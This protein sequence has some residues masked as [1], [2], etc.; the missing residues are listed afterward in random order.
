MTTR[1]SGTT[2]P[3]E[4]VTI[5]VIWPVGVCAG[6]SPAANDAVRATIRKGRAFV[7]EQPPR[8]YFAKIP[9]WQVGDETLLLT[10]IVEPPA[11]R[12]S[13]R[14]DSRL[15]AIAEQFVN[16]T[17]QKSRAASLHGSE[18]LSCTVALSLPG[19]RF[20]IFAQLRP[21]SKRFGF[22][23]NHSPGGAAFL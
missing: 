3:L 18:S 21:P 5:P 12:D 13:R 8:N 6:S 2:A 15:P 20:K 1:T 7:K 22:G 10:Q 17:F 14:F 4:S 11:Q 19:M 16:E 23:G 9:D